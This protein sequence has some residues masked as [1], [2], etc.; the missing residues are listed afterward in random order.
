MKNRTMLYLLFFQLIALMLLFPYTP[1]GEQFMEQFFPQGNLREEE[2][3]PTPSPTPQEQPS[4]PPTP[5]PL[6]KFYTKIGAELP[7]YYD[8]V[9]IRTQN[10]EFSDGLLFRLQQLGVPMILELREDESAVLGIFDQAI[11]LNL[12]ADRMLVFSEGKT[13]PLFYLDGRIRVQDGDLNMIFE[14]RS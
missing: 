9:S 4:P 2:L 13:I 5:V 6:S 12:D 3:I 8:L 11:A 14:R 1:K 7:G 10:D